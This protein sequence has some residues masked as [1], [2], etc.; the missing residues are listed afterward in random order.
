MLLPETVLRTISYYESEA[1]RLD[2]YEYHDH[3]IIHF[4]A[5][6]KRSKKFKW[7]CVRATEDDG[8]TYVKTTQEYLELKKQLD[9]YFQSKENDLR[10]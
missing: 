5:F 1:L 4:K 6:W 3:I 2:S 9:K 8:K 7:Q 10:L